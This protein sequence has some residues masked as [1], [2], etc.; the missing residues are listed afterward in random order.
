[1]AFEGQKC[2]KEM[3]AS[4]NNICSKIPAIKLITF[5]PHAGTVNLY[6]NCQ[7]AD[8]RSNKKFKTPKEMQLR[9]FPGMMYRLC[10]AKYFGG[11]K[12]F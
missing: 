6:F 2:Q 11:N 3:T 12:A 8:L 1:M 4:K 9:L 7:C 5:G 10:F